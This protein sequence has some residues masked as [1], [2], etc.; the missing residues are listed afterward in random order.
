MSKLDEQKWLLQK[1]KIK[2]KDLAEKLKCPEGLI[3]RYF[4]RQI[5]DRL[6]KQAMHDCIDRC[7]NIK[8]REH[9]KVLLPSS[10]DRV[11]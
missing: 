3:L 6:T 7:I 1:Y 10:K 11:Q 5:T 9:G 4:N 8:V 2:R